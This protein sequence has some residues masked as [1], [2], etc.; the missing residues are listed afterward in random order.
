M[1]TNSIPPPTPPPRPQ[2][3][4]NRQHNTPHRFL[5]DDPSAWDGTPDA[6]SSLSRGQA[7]GIGA[8]ALLGAGGIVVGQVRCRVGV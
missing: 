2:T 7:L 4:H 5:R 8:A 1:L 6:F 3:N